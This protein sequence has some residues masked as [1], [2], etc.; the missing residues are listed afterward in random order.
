VLSEL[1]ATVQVLFF[2]HLAHDVALA[3]RVSAE[4]GSGAIAFHELG[5]ERPR[6]VLELLHGER[7]P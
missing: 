2:T 3:R 1:G 5:G 7:S 4:P 6:E